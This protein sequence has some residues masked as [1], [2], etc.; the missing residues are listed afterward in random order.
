MVM[1]CAIKAPFSPPERER[2]LPQIKREISDRR[3]G[4][5]REQ[6]KAGRES[7]HPHFA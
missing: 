5:D 3:R 6:A 4:R 1:R 2:E 7:L